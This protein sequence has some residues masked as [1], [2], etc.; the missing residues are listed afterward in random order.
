[1]TTRSFLDQ[2]GNITSLSGPPHQII[3]LVPSQT[4]LLAD[5]GLEQHVAGITKFCVHPP[6]WRKKKK[7]VGG[8]KNFHFD[9]IDQLQPDLIIGNKEENY[10]E[11]IELLRRKYPVWM[12][13][14]FTLKDALSMIETVGLITEKEILAGQIAN[15]IITKFES[16]KK[17]GGQS[18]LYLIWRQP[19]MAAGNNTFIDSMLTTIGLSNALKSKER[20][21]QITPEAIKNLAPD[22]IFLSSE[23]YPFNT[24]HLAELRQINSTSKVL[25]VDGEMF[26]WYGSRLIKAADYFSRLELS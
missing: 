3:S 18:V 14:I 10:K 23:P 8:T 12:S 25:L 1:M 13:D 4:E 16:I 20:Y 2:L 17:Y 19:W 24:Q 15:E 7:I 5:L 9:A 26:S 6:E 22:Y 21:P 11:G